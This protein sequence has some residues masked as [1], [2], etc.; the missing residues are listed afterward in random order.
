MDKSKVSFDWMLG[1]WQRSNDKVGQK[2]YESW[3]K[4][5]DTL[6]LGLGYTLKEQD[7]IWREHVRFFKKD[8]SWYFSVKGKGD[9]LSTDF[10]LSKITTQSFV[11]ENP[12]NEFPKM[13]SYNLK[14]DSLFAKITGGGPDV[15]FKFGKER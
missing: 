10:M 8:T 2:T 1:S 13:I 14:G 15:E 12:N 9:T 6:Y 5:T 11:C 3:S 7:T 4:L